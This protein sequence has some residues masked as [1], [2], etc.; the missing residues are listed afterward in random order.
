MG[1]ISNSKF[2][3]PP[4]SHSKR[5]F[6]YTGRSIPA[7]WS[8]TALC[9]VET[10]ND[11]KRQE[12][13]KLLLDPCQSLLW[14]CWNLLARP[15][16]DPK[17]CPPECTSGKNLSARAEEIQKL[18]SNML[19]RLW[20]RWVTDQAVFFTC[21]KVRRYWRTQNTF[22]LQVGV[23]LVLFVFLTACSYSN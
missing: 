10:K 7:T 11:I 4:S 18:D 17:T 15:R 13:C 5:L 12:L 2:L 21:P 1:D 9:F 14:I 16:L 22:W 19:E 3:F 23:S 6:I 20:T 8:C